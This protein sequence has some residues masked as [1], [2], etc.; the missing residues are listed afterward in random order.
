MNGPSIS[1][2]D[3]PVSMHS[4]FRTGLSLSKYSPISVRNLSETKFS[5]KIGKFRVCPILVQIWHNL[6]PLPPF[7]GLTVWNNIRLTFT[8]MFVH[9][10]GQLW[11]RYSKIGIICL[12]LHE[13]PW[14]TSLNFD[15][16]SAFV[17][18]IVNL[19][20][21]C[22]NMNENFM[23][24][25]EKTWHN[26]LLQKNCEYSIV[27]LYENVMKFNEP[28]WKLQ[29]LSMKISW[30]S[31]KKLENIPV[32]KIW[33]KYWESLWKLHEIFVKKTWKVRI[34]HTFS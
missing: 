13:K 5:M 8:H 22:R 21:N 30:K 6:R 7:Q 1:T 27:N 34:W 14:K 23:K 2:D 10:F 31:M 11:S 26:I 12:N 17:E 9:N 16:I 33:I 18:K 15:F 32:K 28:Q 4:S 25:Y 20:E 19:N 3:R 29:E 24:N